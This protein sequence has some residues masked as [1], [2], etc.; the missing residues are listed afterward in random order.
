MTEQ[1]RVRILIGSPEAISPR[2][3]SIVRQDLVAQSRDFCH[4]HPEPITGNNDPPAM[5]A[6]RATAHAALSA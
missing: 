2:L 1:A 3:W 6:T 4:Y 5:W